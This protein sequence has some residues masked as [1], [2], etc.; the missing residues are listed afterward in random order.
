MVMNF[1][2]CILVNRLNG[3]ILKCVKGWILAWLLF[4]WMIGIILIHLYV[5]VI[6]F[7]INDMREVYYVDVY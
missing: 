7:I 6:R 1:S 2:L 5:G 4:R 3:L